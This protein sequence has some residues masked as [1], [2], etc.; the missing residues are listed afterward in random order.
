M[1]G[2]IGDALWM[3]TAWGPV[4]SAEWGGVEPRIE[5]EPAEKKKKAFN[6]VSEYNR[7]AA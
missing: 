5:R 3:T 7:G 2:K 1:D 4:K 6:I